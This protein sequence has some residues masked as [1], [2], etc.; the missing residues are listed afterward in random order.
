MFKRRFPPVVD[1]AIF[2]ILLQPIENAVTYR[3][4]W[5]PFETPLLYTK[6]ADPTQRLRPPSDAAMLAW[7]PNSTEDGQEYESPMSCG[8]CERVGLEREF[9]DTWKSLEKLLPIDRVK[10]TAINPLV[11]HFLLRAYEQGRF[12]G[13]L[14][15]IFAV[16]AL[17][18]GRKADRKKIG[19]RIH[20]LFYSE[21]KER[22]FL[23]QVSDLCHVAGAEKWSSAEWFCHLYKMRN[24]YVHGMF[25]D[26]GRSYRGADP[27]MQDVVAA[28]TLTRMLISAACQY[29]EKNNF[30]HRDEFIKMLDQ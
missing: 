14:N 27:F 7:A 18:G 23:E 13:L 4:D 25:L 6:H 5:R 17:L 24:N 1:R 12:E 29:V 16:E 21:N 8:S 15:H 22:V 9:G 2:C 28:H 30:E 20:N 26:S 11:E 19:K 3:V 10:S